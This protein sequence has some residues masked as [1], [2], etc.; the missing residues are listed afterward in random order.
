MYETFLFFSKNTLREPFFYGK[1]LEYPLHYLLVNCLYKVRKH[2]KRF[3]LVFYKWVL[4]PVR[5]PHYPF[6]KLIHAKKIILP[7]RIYHPQNDHSLHVPGLFLTHKNL[8][9]GIVGFRKFQN[10]FDHL[11][12][13]HI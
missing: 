13:G 3:V 5:T 1:C 8:F 12:L 11:I 9:F 4:L 7:V 10:F 6:A 2:R